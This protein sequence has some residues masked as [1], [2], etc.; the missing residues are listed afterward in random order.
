MYVNEYSKTHNLPQN[1]NSQFYPAQSLYHHG[2]H[3]VIARWRITNILQKITLRKMSHV[4]PL[5]PADMNPV[6]NTN[7]ENPVLAQGA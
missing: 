1:I 7:P 5:K 3:I 6:A 4:Y 2:D